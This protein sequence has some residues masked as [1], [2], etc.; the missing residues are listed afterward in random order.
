M[1]AASAVHLSTRP[2]REKLAEYLKCVA[3]RVYAA[4]GGDEPPAD[5]ADAPRTAPPP[6]EPPRPPDRS[7]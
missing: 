6:F 4:S 1:I 3:T 2:R 7:S 5:A